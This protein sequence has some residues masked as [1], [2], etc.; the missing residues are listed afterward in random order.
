MKAEF[1]QNVPS[2]TAFGDDV[3]TNVGL[4]TRVENV[5][6]QNREIMKILTKIRQHVNVKN[7]FPTI[8]APSNAPVIQ[9][10]G[11][12]RQSGAG[13]EVPRA[14]VSAV[15]GEH[16]SLRKRSVSSKRGRSDDD[17][18]TKEE[19]WAVV[20]NKR[21]NRKPA[22]KGSSKAT[23]VGKCVAAPFEIVIGNT[24]PDSS[25]NGIKEVLIEVSKQMPQGM[26][27]LIDLELEVVECLTKPRDNQPFKPWSKSWRVKVENRFKEHFLR[28]ESIPEGWT[29]R[30]YFPPRQPR[31]PVATLNPIKRINTGSGGAIIVNSGQSPQWGS[32][33]QL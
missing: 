29:I 10:N 2:V 1:L 21:R 7:H 11:N 27:L 23:L 5:E 13:V 19:T 17:D 12:N 3:E 20:A 33:H 14:R 31:A 15:V 24:H 9:V 32:S 18:A 4:T 6:N 30:K 16:A 25:E 28:P 22:V 8:Q 26:E